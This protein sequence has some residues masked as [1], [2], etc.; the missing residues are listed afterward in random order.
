MYMNAD[1]F[2]RYLAARQSEFRA[3]LTEMGLALKP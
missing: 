1:E 3:F 2:G